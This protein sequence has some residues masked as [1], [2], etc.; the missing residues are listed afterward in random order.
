M[1]F[2]PLSKKTVNNLGERGCFYVI[3]LRI[4]Y[5]LLY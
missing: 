3:S 5:R 4:S 1:Y 2:A